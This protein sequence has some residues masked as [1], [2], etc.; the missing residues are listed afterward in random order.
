MQSVLRIGA[1]FPGRHSP[2]WAALRIAAYAL[3]GG[4]NSRLSALLREEKGYTYSIR[5]ALEPQHLG[6][7]FNVA[8][9]VATD[10]SGP[11]LADIVRVVRSTLEGGIDTAERDQAADYFLRIGPVGTRRAPPSPI[12]L[13]PW[14]PTTCP[15]TSS[16]GITPPCARSPPA[17]LAGAVPAPRLRPAVPGRRR[18]RVGHRTRRPRGVAG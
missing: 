3:G 2:D 12:R 14:S 18:R 15:T 10:V 6:G 11:A 16:T 1:P 5:A 8:C 13:P 7:L 17:G 9:S 4:M